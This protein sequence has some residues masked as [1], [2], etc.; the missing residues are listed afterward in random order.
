MAGVPRLETERLVLREW[1]DEDRPRWAAMCADPEV[2]RFIR[3]GDL[4]TREE[5][6]VSFG[7]ADAHWGEHGFGLWALDERGSGFVGFCGVQYVK[8]ASGRIEIGWRLARGA[9]GRGL[10]TE[11]AL[12]ARDYA[13]ER[14]AL[15]R[16]IGRARPGNRASQRVMQKLGMTYASDE[17]D[18]YELP[19]RVYELPRGRWRPG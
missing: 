7:I 10:A 6:D 5:A 1:R 16:L 2:M 3:E 15:E 17:V 18:E 14:L 8:D 4:L 13:F 12:V 19:L 9:W 11:A